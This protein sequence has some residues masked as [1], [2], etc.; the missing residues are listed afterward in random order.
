MRKIILL[1]VMLLF[2]TTTSAFAACLLKGRDKDGQEVCKVTFTHELI[3]TTN[4][5]F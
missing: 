4:Y 2:L 1:A 5:Y 3:D